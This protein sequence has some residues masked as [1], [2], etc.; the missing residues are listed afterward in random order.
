L[1]RLTGGAIPAAL[2]RVAGP[3]STGV[4]DSCAAAARARHEE[5]MEAA[6]SERVSVAFFVDPDK[7]G[8][9]LSLAHTRPRVYAS[10]QLF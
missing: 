6:R 10:S 1:E 7:D 4:D 9:G 3:A 5:L 2:H 8:R